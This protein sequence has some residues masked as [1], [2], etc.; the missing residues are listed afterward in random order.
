MHGC[1]VA[2]APP[3]HHLNCMQIDGT[4]DTNGVISETEKKF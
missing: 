2:T 1:M 4:T 3:V